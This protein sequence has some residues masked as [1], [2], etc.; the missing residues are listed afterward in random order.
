MA[1]IPELQ[2]DKDNVQSEEHIPDC[3][4]ANDVGECGE[5]PANDGGADNLEFTSSC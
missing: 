2:P 5:I 1:D 3:E 4:Q